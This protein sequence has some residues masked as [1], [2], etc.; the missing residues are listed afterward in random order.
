MS[1][2]CVGWNMILVTCLGFRS[3]RSVKN[4]NRKLQSTLTDINVGQFSEAL[5]DHDVIY[6][7]NTYL[8]PNPRAP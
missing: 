3:H 4:V 1:L 2:K 6:K 7:V 5:H 8:V